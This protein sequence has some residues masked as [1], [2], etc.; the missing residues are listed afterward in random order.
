MCRRRLWVVFAGIVL[1]AAVAA[2]A[3]EWRQGNGRVEGSVKNAKGEPIADATVSLRLPGGKGPDLKT[4][5]NGHWA[6]LGIIGGMWN[7]DISAPGYQSRSIAYNVKEFERNPNVDVVLEP[8]VQKG[9]PHEEITVGG[10]KISKETADALD[11]GNAAWNEALKAQESHDA[12]RNAPAPGK[13]SGQVV[14]QCEKDADAAK[15]TKFGEAT[16]FYEKALPELSD[17]TALLTKL[18]MAGFLTQGYGQAEKYA[19]MIVEKDPANT[20]SWLMIAEL[21]VQKGNLAAGKEALEK[22]PA[23]KITDPTVY[24]NLGIV[25]Y[26]KNKPADAEQ[27]FSKAIEKK[28]DLSEGYYYRGLARYQISASMKDK[29][30]ASAKRGE[31]KA[32]FQKYMQI[33]PNGKDAET[34]KELLKSLK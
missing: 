30:A 27:Y 9:P 4:N 19:R 20:T 23:E 2:R 26:N 18:E 1:G 16:G 31:A 14:A 17:N 6:L 15:K 32:D 5:K 7:I 8:E 12:C 10:K 11:K 21:E 28:N 3:Q 22:V 24:M 29:Q 25:C 34:V 13:E 33:D